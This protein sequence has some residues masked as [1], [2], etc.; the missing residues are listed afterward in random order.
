M[1]R[2]IDITGV[3]SKDYQTATDNVLKNL[4][5]KGHRVQRFSE[6]MRGINNENGRKEFRVDL[7]VSV[8]I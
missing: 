1:L 2:V 8:F 5:D 3:S 7:K 6:K 4:S